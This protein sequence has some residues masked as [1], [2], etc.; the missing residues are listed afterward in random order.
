[1]EKM[2]AKQKCGAIDSG[3]DLDNK[4]SFR[5]GLNAYEDVARKEIQHMVDIGVVKAFLWHDKTPWASSSFGVPRRLETY[6]L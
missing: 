2:Y 5:G 6:I 1:M 4:E 3:S